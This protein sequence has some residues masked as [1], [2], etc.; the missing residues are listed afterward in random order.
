M[1]GIGAA[2]RTFVFPG[3]Y[4]EVD[5]HYRDRGW[6]D[7]LPIVPPTA[8]VVGEFLRWT[9]RDS[10]E[11]VGVLPPRQGEA[12]VD[13][14]AANAVMAGCRPEDLPGILDVRLRDPDL[15]HGEV[16]GLISYMRTDAVNLA[17]EA[18]AE[19]RDVII[20]G[21]DAL[22]VVT[23]GDQVAER[24][25][26]NLPRFEVRRWDD[27]SVVDVMKHEHLVL[28]SE[29]LNLMAMP[30]FVANIIF[31]SPFISSV[32]INLSLF[33]LTAL[34]PPFLG[35]ENWFMLTLLIIPFCV[36]ITKEPLNS[37]TGITDVISS[38]M[39]SKFM[40]AFPFPYLATSGIS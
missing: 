19:I 1:T 22:V 34:I 20:S 5:A 32:P 26:R 27:V 33:N 14:I 6:T 16:V 4:D 29:A 36:V 3:G 2:A 10:R 28:T 35:L 8:A 15:G 18:V 12:T 30:S 38:F 40:T 13:R 37:L 39:F 31:S 7:G 11:V 17:N 21:G 25:I 24:S 9:D 23:A